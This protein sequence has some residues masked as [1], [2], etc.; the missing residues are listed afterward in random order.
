MKVNRERL[1]GRGEPR[2]EEK[3]WGKT[4]PQEDATDTGRGQQQDHQRNGVSE[5][6]P[7]A[8]C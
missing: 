5:T 3:R 1:T 8:G 7:V 6:V 4:T 2:I